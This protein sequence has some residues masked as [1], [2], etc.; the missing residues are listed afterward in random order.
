MVYSIQVG[1]FIIRATQP[2]PTDPREIVVSVRVKPNEDDPVTIRH[3]VIRRRMK[4]D[5][6]LEWRA[7]EDECYSS[8][9][10]LIDNYMA[11]GRP[12]N[13]EVKSSV[14]IRSIKRKS[15]EFLHEDIKLNDLLGEGQYG[16][17]RAG[18]ALVNG[19][20]LSVAVKVAKVVKEESQ[21]AKAKEKIKEMMHEAR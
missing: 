15:W 20:K 8:V 7:I 10:E 1:D 5:G 9:R 12:L 6:S 17:V 18:E 2:R 3:I 4:E 13:P 21:M 19:R 14:L 16:E 11:S